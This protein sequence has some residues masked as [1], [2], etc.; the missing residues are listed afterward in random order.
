MLAIA[1]A[2]AACRD[3]V[4][5][6]PPADI[7]SIVSGNQQ[8]GT[9]GRSLL[10]PLV[11]QLTDA[12]GT[13]R[14][15]VTITW[16]V[17]RGGG[18]VIPEASQTGLDGRASAIWTLGR[19]GGS[20]S[21]SV[22]ASVT[23]ATVTTAATVSFE[24]TA[25]F[26]VLAVRYDG[27]RWSTHL[28]DSMATPVTFLAAVWGAS[29]STVFAGGGSESSNLDPCRL[30]ILKFDGS[31]W[32]TSNCPGTNIVTAISIG[33]RSPSDVF[34]VVRDALPPSTRTRVLHFDG[35]Q[36]SSS[37]SRGCSFCAQF[38]AVWVD[39]AS[40]VFVVGDSG[41]VLHYDGSTWT[42]Q[43][44]GTTRALDGI[45]GVSKND[46]FAVGSS[47]TIVHYDGTWTTQNSG[48]TRHLRSVSGTSA[49]DVFA[50]GEAGTVL[51][52]NGSSWTP[53]ASGI[54]Q[55]LH[56]VWALSP[57]DVFAV[58]SGGTILHYNGTA[59][60][61]QSSGV[62]VDFDGVWGSASNNAFAV[63]KAR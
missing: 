41:A 10:Q 54:T 62:L 58:G 46:L 59:W 48:T 3:S 2:G 49:T 25:S 63:G 31:N 29:A 30:V 17:T 55:D 4:S 36:W 22:R 33:G 50:V 16:T 53:Q 37:Y 15:G 61:A 1:S 57:N 19:S 20:Q 43:S 42:T 60:T 13:P 39:Q 45:W 11:I 24:A 47:G 40:D 35:Q 38:S 34:A 18:S 52:Y 23:D 32:S 27:V 28:V 12:H 26:A 21:Q 6:P 5:A 8:S 7:L 44:S 9:A 51:H 14:S 56:A